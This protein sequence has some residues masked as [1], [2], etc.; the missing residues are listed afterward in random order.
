[1]KQQ[2]VKVGSHLLH[3][4][5]HILLILQRPDDGN[6][7]KAFTLAKLYNHATKMS[8]LVQQLLIIPSH[9]LGETS[10]LSANTQIRES[11][12]QLSKHLG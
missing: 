11:E 8:V 2:C 5:K 7:A 12:E 10:I 6:N 9:T 1:M 4:P 3:K